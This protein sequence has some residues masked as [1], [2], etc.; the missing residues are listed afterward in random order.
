MNPAAREFQTL[1]ALEAISQVA[2]EI[3]ALDAHLAAVPLWDSGKILRKLGRNLKARLGRLEA[4]LD[5]KLVVTLIGPCGA[6]KST[7]LNALLGGEEVAPAGTTRP[8]TREVM[9]VCRDA[10]DASQ[11]RQ[12]LGETVQIRTYPSAEAL[13]DLVLIDTPDTDSTAQ[14]RHLPL[15]RRAVAISDVLLCVFN[16]ENPKTRDHLD[17]ITPLTALF[18]G[19]SLV[20]V[21]NKCDRLDEA[22][23]KGEILPEFS[24]YLQQAWDKPPVRLLC[25]SARNHLAQPDWVA[26]AE[27]RHGFNQFEQLL[28]LLAAAAGAPGQVLERRVANARELRKYLFSITQTRL[29]AVRPQLES[30]RKA[31]ASAKVRAVAAAL[32]GL[33]G[34][35]FE[36]LPGINLQLYQ[37]LAQRW[38]GPLGAMLA[39]W[40][41]LMVFGLGMLSLLRFG[42]PLSQALGLVQSI[43]HLSASRDQVSATGDRQR[44]RRAMGRFKS[45]L[46]G[47]WPDIAETLV[48]A[49]FSPAVR[50]LQELIPEAQSLDEALAEVWRETLEREIDRA[51]KTLSHGLLQLMFNVPVLAI[52]GHMGWITVNTYL[53]GQYLSGDFFLHGLFTVAVVL[54]FSFFAFQLLV[55][56]MAGT[57]RISRRAFAALQSQV[58]SLQ[59]LQSNPVSEQVDRMIGLAESLRE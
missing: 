7:L 37:R 12:V 10:R 31:M 34:D 20:V 29:G 33:R 6:G 17:L 5:R 59:A 30:A 50:D 25:L 23:L 54:C 28:E 35:D 3:D 58:E 52:L 51:A 48:R 44:V 14:A 21:L 24:Q 2:R 45:A 11:I 32:E 49:G 22:E 13:G 16:A 40:A 18:A 8:T 42:R 47:T 41:R 43:R 57:A 15:I 39:L 9:A 27:P 26:D 53:R 4:R 56:L 19:D 1:E 38:L 46:L 55:R 36:T